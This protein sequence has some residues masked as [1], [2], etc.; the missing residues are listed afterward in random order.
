MRDDGRSK[1]KASFNWS[2]PKVLCDFRVRKKVEK[3]HFSDELG[4][5]RVV[6]GGPFQHK[7]TV[8]FGR[9]PVNDFPETAKKKC[10]N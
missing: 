5:F 4:R 3:C 1:H 7:H 6:K 8:R 2:M 10:N 9:S